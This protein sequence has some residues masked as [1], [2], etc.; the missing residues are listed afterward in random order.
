MYL[1]LCFSGKKGHSFYQVAL[2]SLPQ[3]RAVLAQERLVWVLGMGVG[4]GQGCS[5]WPNLLSE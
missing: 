5:Q 2:A 3:S 1:C 4:M